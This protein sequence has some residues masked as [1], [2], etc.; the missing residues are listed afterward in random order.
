MFALCAATL[1]PSPVAA[2]SADQGENAPARPTEAPPYDDQLLRLAEILG[3]LHYL[4]SL[5]KPDADPIWR[6]R[7][8]ELMTAEEPTTDRRQRM[9]DR[10]N[11]GYNGFS[12]IYQRCTPSAELALQRYLREGADIAQQVVARYSR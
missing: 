12:D 8:T 6:D 4:S 3:A 2:Q 1:S 11:R 10:F 5:C 7:M 9:V